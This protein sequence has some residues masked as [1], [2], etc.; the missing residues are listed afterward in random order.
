MIE[1]KKTWLLNESFDDGLKHWETFGSV[2]RFMNDNGKF[3]VELGPNGGSLSQEHWV[4]GLEVVWLGTSLI[5]E[6]SGQGIDLKLECLDRNGKVILARTSKQRIEKSAGIY[7]RTHAFTKRIRITVSVSDKCKATINSVLLTKD[8]N[9]Q[10]THP[11]MLPLERLMQPLWKSSFVFAEAVLL[12]GKDGFPAQGRLARIPSEVISVT[13]S[14]TMTTYISDRDFKITSNRIEA[15]PHS[16]IPVMSQSEFATGKFPWTRTDGRHIFVT[17]K[18][19]KP[20]RGPVPRPQ[21]SNLTGTAARIA[22]KHPVRIVA[23]GDSIT[24]GVNVSGFLNQAPYIPDWP[25]LAAMQL[26]AIYK[27]QDITLTNVSLGGQTSSWAK[28]NVGDVVLPLKPNIVCIAFGMNDFWT[29]EPDQFEKNIVD[30]IT[31][32]RKSAPSTE[33][34]LVSPMWFAPSYTDDETYIRRFLG[35]GARLRS[36]AASGIAHIDMSSM[37]KQ[38][39]AMK[40]FQDFTTDPMHPN[41]YFSRWHAQ[42]L[43]RTIGQHE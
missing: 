42:C 37:S 7:L 25:T 14:T 6:S 23:F 2:R 32:I 9:G 18:T 30:T 29:I 33:I 34:I 1:N 11:M 26:R 17:Y 15:L 5:S 35:Y 19:T 39:Y 24:Q 21:G 13:D 16:R 36:L 22:K 43:V 38:L 27:T 41:D 20:W 31:T 3:S 12:V 10:A 40:H 4:D 8:G 28:E